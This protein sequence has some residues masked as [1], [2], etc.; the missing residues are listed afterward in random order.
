MIREKERQK[1][2]KIGGEDSDNLLEK[3]LGHYV[4]D[5]GQLESKVDSKRC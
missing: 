1:V 5:C 4:A 2:T 3:K